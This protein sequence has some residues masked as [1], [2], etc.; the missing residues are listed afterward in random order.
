MAR[1]G[2]KGEPL[3][4]KHGVKYVVGLIHQPNSYNTVSFLSVK[5]SPFVPTSHITVFFGGI[6]LAFVQIC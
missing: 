4:K 6:Y 3:L 5:C 2:G 1:V